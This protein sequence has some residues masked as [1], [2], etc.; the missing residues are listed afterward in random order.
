M[1]TNWDKETYDACAE[2]YW[3]M[4]GL[5]VAIIE[6]PKKKDFLKCGRIVFNARAIDIVGTVYDVVWKSSMGVCPI[7]HNEWLNC[8]KCSFLTC[9]EIEQLH[10]ECVPCNKKN[11]HL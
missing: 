11:S 2:M 10:V 8:D 9:P 3:E 5:R 4:D 6:E 1:S 7:N